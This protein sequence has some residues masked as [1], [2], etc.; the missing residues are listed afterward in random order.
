MAKAKYVSVHTLRAEQTAWK[1][2]LRVITSELFQ[3]DEVRRLWHAYL[4]EVDFCAPPTRKV[5]HI[6]LSERARGGRDEDLVDLCTSAV[7][8]TKSGDE[9][10]TELYR[11]NRRRPLP[12]E[13]EDRH[14]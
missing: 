6:A 11:M 8:P 9:A 1:D 3:N 5:A 7:L 14:C 2:T 10:C 13:S 12:L 4:D